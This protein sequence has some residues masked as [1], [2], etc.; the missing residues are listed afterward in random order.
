MKFIAFLLLARVSLAVTAQGL[1]LTP[2]SGAATTL[3]D[4]HR[5][6]DLHSWE[7]VT[8]IH[9]CKAGGNIV[10]NDDFILST[11]CSSS[12]GYTSWRDGR[13]IQVVSG[14]PSGSTSDLTFR[15]RRDNTNHTI[16]LEVWRTDTGAYTYATLNPTPWSPNQPN[17][18]GK[19]F[20]VGV[21]YKPGITATVDYVRLF[22]RIEAL[23]S[24]PSA[25]PGGDL[26]DW[27]FDGDYR[28]S[29]RSEKALAP[30]GSP[31]FRPTPSYAPIV[32]FTPASGCFVS[33]TYPTKFCTVIAGSPATLSTHAYSPNLNDSLVY[34]WTQTGGAPTTLANAT[35]A[36]A[37]ATG[38]DRFGEY[39]YLLSVT[40]TENKKTSETLRIGAVTVTRDNNCLISDVPGPLS[41]VVG[42]LTPWGSSKC[43]PW[44]WYDMAEAANGIHLQSRFRI[45]ASFNSAPA[46]GTISVQKDTVSVVGSGTHFTTECGGGSCAGWTIFIWWDA[47]L[48]S[49]PLLPKE[50]PTGRS[51]QVIKAVTDDNH[52]V[53]DSGI[54]KFNVPL[55]LAQNVH[56]QYLSPINDPNFQEVIVGFGWQSQ[57]SYTWN[58]YDNGTA[59][60]RLYFRTGIT[61]FL[62]Q[63]RLLNDAWY[64]W[65]IDQ[66]ESSNN[67]PRV[68]NLAGLMVRALDGQPGY[69]PGIE[70]KQ[71]MFG[72]KP[73]DPPGAYDPREAGYILSY[74]GAGVEMDPNGRVKPA[75]CAAVSNAIRSFFGPQ[76]MSNGGFWVNNYAIN[77]SLP[78][79]G[80]G[81]EPFIL[82]IAGNGIKEAYRALSDPNGCNNPAVAREAFKMLGSLLKYIYEY[83]VAGTRTI[84]AANGGGQGAAGIWYSIG[85]EASGEPPNDWVKG[86]GTISGH[87]GTTSVTGAGAKFTQPKPNGFARCDGSTFVGVLKSLEV[88][89][90]VA[91]PNDETLTLGEPIVNSF[92]GSDYQIVQRDAS[93]ACAPSKTE[94]CFGGNDSDDAV[95]LPAIYGWYYHESGDNQFKTWGEDWFSMA[96]GGPAGGPGSSGP[97][98]G[99][100]SS[101]QTV[102]SYGYI[103]ALPYCGSNAPP[104]NPGANVMFHY[105][106]D[107]GT[108]SG[109]TADASGFLAYLMTAPAR[110]ASK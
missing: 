12:A 82:G 16:S 90:V 77:S 14:I 67:T 74:L 78:S 58:Y 59:Y 81:S 25:D 72:T 104:C 93:R 105:G 87:A 103:S 61:Q 102:G 2:A 27:E 46:H 80:K 88:Y 56:Y 106:K 85:F 43:D 45:P 66:G 63:A 60:Y 52:A 19:F 20:D 54:F 94:W 8:R 18:A 29:R 101:G 17:F 92:A 108:G 95:L 42:P 76:Q 57:P 48:R 49:H 10:V 22:S 9:D 107:F 5:L 89:R 71:Q 4:T 65:N 50:Y 7:L 55:N 36:H 23:G 68:T 21:S 70:A 64:I 38:L 91:C 69:W 51:V 100:H 6:Q 62:T 1:V 15:I 35:T 79:Y 53:L 40:D 31:T 30:V 47:P 110:S 109:Y 98:A 33:N 26:G 86:A 24:I 37:S 99:P 83:G 75:Y 96:Y 32:A 39:D 41:F 73:P 97:P 44:P 3:A 84:P 11:D 13:G 28:D 34:S